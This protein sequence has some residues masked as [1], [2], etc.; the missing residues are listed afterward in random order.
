MYKNFFKRLLDFIIALTVLL[1]LSPVILILTVILA[2]S[3]KG[4][5]FFI[6]R[7]PGKNERIFKIIKFKTMSDKK[8]AAGNLLMDD[9]RLT[10]IGKFVRK[11]SLDEI[12]Q[13]YNVMINDMSLIGPR[14][15]V[16]EYLPFY[17]DKHRKRH[18]VKPGITGLAQVKGRNTMKFSERFDND[19]FYVENLSFLLDC[20]IILLTVK[21]I[22][23]KSSTVL[24]G[25]TVDDIDDLGIT[26]N[27]SSNHF[28]KKNYEH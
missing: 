15:L 3:V 2:I 7:R 23:F 19:V 11:T 24:N 9:E 14:P 26:K 10:A 17:N 21:S 16:P 6:Q 8:D 1:L 13:L 18:D 25:Q 22:L 20:K 4:S 12:P 27:L 28:R 5:P